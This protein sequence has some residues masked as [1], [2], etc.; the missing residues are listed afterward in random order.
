MCTS[1]SSSYNRGEK[2]REKKIPVLSVVWM[3]VL[4]DDLSAARSAVSL[5]A[6]TGK[7]MAA[8]LAAH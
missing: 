6:S 1:P 4:T 7:M 5:V 8:S 3:V 2:E